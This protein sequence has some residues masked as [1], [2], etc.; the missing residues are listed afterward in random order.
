MAE[1]GRAF[2]GSD[3]WK[4]GT[5]S[6]YSDGRAVAWAEDTDGRGLIRASVRVSAEREWTKPDRGVRVF[7]RNL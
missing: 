4:Q 5:E 3:D 7:V 2:D 1:C 6:F